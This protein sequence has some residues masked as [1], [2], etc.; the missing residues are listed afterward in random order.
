MQ[1]SRRLGLKKRPGNKTLELVS[2]GGRLGQGVRGQGTKGE[3]D[4]LEEPKN[5][6]VK[7][8]QDMRKQLGQKLGGEKRWKM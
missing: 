6:I 7:A 8:R 1:A 5:K 2:A 4:R 3:K